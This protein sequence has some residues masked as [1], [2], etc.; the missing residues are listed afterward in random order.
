VSRRE[1]IA[2]AD[3]L[4]MRAGEKSHAMIDALP[5]FER[6]ASPS[7]SGRVMLEVGRVATHIGEVERGLAQDLRAL[8]GPADLGQWWDRALAALEMRAAAADEIGTAGRSDDRSAYLR[9]FRDFV[10]AG[11]ASTAALRGYGFHVCARP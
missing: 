11:E 3:R 10:R 8:D 1:F 9:A 7:V 2:A 4:C 6:I 5:P